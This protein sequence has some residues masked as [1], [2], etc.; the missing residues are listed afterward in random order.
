MPTE[1]TATSLCESSKSGEG[2]L[3]RRDGAQKA[4]QD[5]IV[6]LAGDSGRGLVPVPRSR[7]AVVNYGGSDS[8][9]APTHPLENR[10]HVDFELS[11]ART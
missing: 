2:K 7:I 9:R 6:R 8:P 11:K 1:R 10:L 4:L 3:M 5:F